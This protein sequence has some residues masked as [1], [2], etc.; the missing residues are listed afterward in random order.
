[1]ASEEE[2]PLIEADS[3]CVELVE[4]PYQFVFRPETQLLASGNSQCTI[5]QQ[6][7]CL[8]AVNRDEE[9]KEQE[10]EVL[11]KEVY[12]LD[13]L[14]LDGSEPQEEGK[15]DPVLLES[16]NEQQQRPAG[17]SMD[18]DQDPTNELTDKHPMRT[19]DEEVNKM[20]QRYGK[21]NFP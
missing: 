4:A 19:V 9:D 15:K 3:I 14:V 17:E 20:V 18:V 2:A 10:I 12:G 21:S 1:M 5:E 6:E 8:E 11:Q 7:S 16:T 13:R